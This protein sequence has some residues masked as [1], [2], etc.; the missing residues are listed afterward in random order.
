MAIGSGNVLY[1]SGDY[2]RMATRTGFLVTVR[3]SGVRDLAWPEVDGPVHAM[4][5]DGAG[6]WFIGGELGHVARRP[7]AGLAH[8]GADGELDPT[9]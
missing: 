7:R 5:P 1:V 8:V 3:G 6:G 9:W 2:D 4:A